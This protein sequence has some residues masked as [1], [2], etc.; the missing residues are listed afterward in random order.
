MIIIRLPP[1]HQPHATPSANAVY[2]IH[3]FVYKKLVLY[4]IIVISSLGILVCRFDDGS[5]HELSSSLLASSTSI[6][7]L[8]DFQL[9][10][11]AMLTQLVRFTLPM[12]EFFTPVLKYLVFAISRIESDSLEKVKFYK[13]T[14]AFVKNITER[15]DLYDH[16]I[17]TG[18]C[19]FKT[20]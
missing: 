12:G 18:H 10:I 5:F 8:V 2:L 6:D 3:S 15:G 4:I 11:S 13:Q 16:I 7:Y 14:T 9:W 20:Q 17:I 19:K 1:P